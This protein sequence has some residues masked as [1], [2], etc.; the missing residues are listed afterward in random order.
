MTSA[1]K[2][3]SLCLLTLAGLSAFAAT[4]NA[5]DYECA[6]QYYSSW[7]EHE[8]GDYYY[9][10]YYYKPYSDYAGHK[11][12]Y[13][14]LHKSKPTKLYYY[15]HYQG[16]YWGYCDLYHGGK[17]AYSRLAPE[18][19]KPKLSEIPDKAFPP[20]GKLPPIPE[21]TDGALLDLPP[22]DLPEGFPAP[23]ATAPPAPEK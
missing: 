8:S 21:S 5:A 16:K 19:Q 11:H 12:H 4:A 18:Y 22:D 13:V 17:P 2:P 20:L 23:N 1:T 3:L 7:H 9:R 14:I 10:K 15:N 6:R